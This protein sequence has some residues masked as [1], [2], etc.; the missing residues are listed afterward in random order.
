LARDRKG[1]NLGQGAIKMCILGSLSKKPSGMTNVNKIL[2][3]LPRTQS[4]DRL[5]DFLEELCTL[6]CVEKV[7]LSS[8]REGLVNYKIIQKGLKS[9]AQFQSTEFQNVRAILGVYDEEERREEEERRLI[10]LIYP[11]YRIPYFLFD[12]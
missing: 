8:S 6:E 9:L 5:K 12:H 7:D 10:K 11:Q 1:K 3:E 2:N 4:P